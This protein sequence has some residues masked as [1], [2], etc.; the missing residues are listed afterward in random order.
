MEINKIWKNNE[1]LIELRGVKFNRKTAKIMVSRWRKQKII[2]LNNSNKIN[3]NWIQIS[4]E[5]LKFF[6]FIIYKY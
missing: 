6:M 2:F 4:D 1:E 5:I 3:F